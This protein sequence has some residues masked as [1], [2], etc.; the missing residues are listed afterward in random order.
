ML[1]RLLALVLVAAS[2]VY[3]TAGWP[4][5]RG[6]LARPGPGFFPAAVGAFGAAVALVW[7]ARAFWRAPSLAG[8][9]EVPEG[10]L[11]RVT[12]TTGTLAGF[13]LLLPWTGYPVAALLFVTLLLRWL[14]AGWTAAAVTGAASAVV[15]YYLFAVLL[16]VP[17]PRGPFPG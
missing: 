5:P 17:L 4:L 8:A 16:D 13:C 6:T 15:S 9:G 11:G 10:G 12:A 7:V 2:G 1:E 14:G 3:L